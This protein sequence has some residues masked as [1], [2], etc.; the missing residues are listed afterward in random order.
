MWTDEHDASAAVELTAKEKLSLRN[1][2]GVRIVT[3]AG[4]VYQGVIESVGGYLADSPNRL[5]LHGKMFG[6]PAHKMFRVK[7]EGITVIDP[8]KRQVAADELRDI[9]AD[10]SFDRSAEHAGR[11]GGPIAVGFRDIA[12]A[13]LGFEA[14]M[15][16][17]TPDFGGKSPEGYIGQFLAVSPAKRVLGEMVDAGELRAVNDKR[18]SIDHRYVKFQYRTKS[19]WVLASQYADSKSRVDAY[20][21]A[22][23]LEKLRAKARQTVADRH[24]D[25]VEAVLAELVATQ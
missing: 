7:A 14:D 21:D 11:N 22:Q 20:A 3:P 9:I 24:A 6:I 16:G 17:T 8:P 1:G 12:R 5:Y 2:D 19:G 23:K 25:E 10:L 18:D 15:H 4:T 13:V